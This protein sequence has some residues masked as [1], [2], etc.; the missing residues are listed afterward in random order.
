MEGGGASMSRGRRSSQ[1]LAAYLRS[2]EELGLIR[3]DNARDAVIITDPDGLRGF[4]DA[5]ARVH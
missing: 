4:G 5:P 1:K 2:F 3:R